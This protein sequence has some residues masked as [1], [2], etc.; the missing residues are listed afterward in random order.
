MQNIAGHYC[1]MASFRRPLFAAYQEV[2]T[3]IH[4]FS[5]DPAEQ[6]EIPKLVR[7]E[8]LT[9]A[10]LAPLAVTNLRAPIRPGISIS[11]ASEEGA[12]AGIATRFVDELSDSG[13]SKAQ[14]FAD[15]LALNDGEPPPSPAKSCSVCKAS[16]N[17]RKLCCFPRCG[18]AA[19]SLACWQLHREHKCLFSARR[20]TQIVCIG[21]SWADAL[22]RQLAK[23]MYFPRKCSV[24]SRG[25][26]KLVFQEVECICAFFSGEDHSGGLGRVAKNHF[27]VVTKACY[28]AVIGG[29]F[30]LLMVRASV[31]DMIYEFRE[32]WSTDVIQ[33]LSIS[34]INNNGVRVHGWLLHNLSAKPP[35]DDLCFQP[36]DG[37]VWPRSAFVF[38]AASIW[39]ADKCVS[40][41]R[42][43]ADLCMQKVWVIQALKCSTRGFSRTGLAAAAVGNIMD[44]M[45]S[46]RAG[47]ET[48]HL[49]SLFKLLDH[50][51]SDV[52][53][54]TGDLL[55][56]SRQAVPYPAPAW[57]WQAVQAYRWDQSQHINVLELS[58]VLNFLRLAARE[59]EWSSLRLFHIVD[60]RVCSC[61]IAKG[62]SSSRLLN[63]ILRRIS[64]LCLA[65]DLY[66]LPV[67]TLSAWNFADIPSRAFAPAK[68]P[69]DHD[70]H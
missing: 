1:F 28:E 12:G 46:M 58:A 21:D 13:R 4:S 53:L 19:C 66:I 59:W 16:L 37:L 18:F 35:V 20:D 47:S 29:R 39:A 70:G 34:F 38:W 23:H 57:Q 43:P 3:F 69:H 44:I 65:C 7:E 48:E 36:E 33:K 56:S 31:Y 49:L 2:F 9:S 55:D 40:E 54:E 67:W 60:S 41:L 61:V 42:L 52:R 62:R 11:D 15:C 68:D 45:S 64:A 14:S 30:F 6:K 8:L 24:L 51:G 26:P 25:V 22:G 17:N 5:E 50:R 32:L 63:R 10:L 27:R